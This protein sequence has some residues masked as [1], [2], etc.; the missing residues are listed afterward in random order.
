M[1]NSQWE[2]EMEEGI[3]QSEL[4][5]AGGAESRTGHSFYRDEH[6]QNA[7]SCT[8]KP[9]PSLRKYICTLQMW[10]KILISSSY[11]SFEQEQ[12]H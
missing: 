5:L 4:V 10:C 3:S 8:S 11:L 6:Q 9:C 12:G 7:K 2:G 1:R